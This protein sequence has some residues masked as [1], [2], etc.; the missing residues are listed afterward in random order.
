MK[1]KINGTVYVSDTDESFK[2][3]IEEVITP[4][5]SVI[6]IP[7]DLSEI[8]MVPSVSENRENIDFNDDSV[9]GY[10]Y[11]LCLTA[12]LANPTY[13]EKLDNLINEYVNDVILVNETPMQ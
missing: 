12:L 2:D 4:R 8:I 9:K 11:Y 13:S 7:D 5:F 1:S 10:K 6:A 3:T